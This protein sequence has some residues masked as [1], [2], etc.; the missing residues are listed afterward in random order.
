VPIGLGSG[1]NGWGTIGTGR[2]GTIGPGGSFSSGSSKGPSVSI[3]Q[4]LSAGDLD[5]AIIRRYIKRNVPKLQY[6][7]E[8]ELLTNPK[9]QGTVTTKFFI[10]PNG[11][12]A[13]VDATGVDPTVASCIAG[14]VKS[15][16]FP[17][18][19]GGG[20]VQVSYPFTFRSTGE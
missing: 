4:P 1:G 19:K 7:Y 9:L 11:D 8:K 16:V 5:K 2:Y 20:G 13:S 10:T 15:I 18:P 3:G 14:V 17:K 6:C 12:V